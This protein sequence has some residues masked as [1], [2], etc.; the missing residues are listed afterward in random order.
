[1]IH[2][3]TENISKMTIP[4]AK[5]VIFDLDGTIL[6]SMRIFNEIVVSNLERS[7][8][9]KTKESLDEIGI[10]LLETNS[11]SQTKP[12]AILIFKI[13]WRVGRTFGL[14]RI[15]CLQF[16]T[17]CLKT[18]K[19]VYKSAKLFPKT[20]ES[21]MKL[22][23]NGYC[24]GICTSANRDQMNFTLKKH[25]LIELFHPK[26]LISR[27]DVINLKPAPEGIFLAMSACSARVDD[28]FYIGDMPTDIIAGDSAG[29]TTIGL[30]TGL[31]GRELLLKFSSPTIVLD[32]IEEAT[33]WILNS[34]N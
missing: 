7:G 16:T 6:D 1:M 31:V 22:V 32:S 8:I 29:V 3:A 2:L 19:K 18:I 21:L 11:T 9:L 34:N 5:T 20:K 10:Q 17:R 23:E 24:L 13:F 4:M 12:G 14:S 27:E 25:E 15:R 33:E 28:C 30:T 26:G